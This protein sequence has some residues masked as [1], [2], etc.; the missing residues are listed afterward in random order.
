MRRHLANSDYNS[1][2]VSSTKARKPKDQAGT[3]CSSLAQ[4]KAAPEPSQESWQGTKA[5]SASAE[6]FLFEIASE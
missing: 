4:L 2:L 6:Q 3:R 1:V 5:A